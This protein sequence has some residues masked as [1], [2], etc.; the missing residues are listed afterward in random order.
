MIS[1]MTKSM[2]STRPSRLILPLILLAS[3]S[4]IHPKV[5]FQK[6]MLLDPLLDPAKDQALLDSV[7]AEPTRRLER[8]SAAGGSVGGATCPTCGG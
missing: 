7:G 4:C 1:F 8:G 5:K 3:V 6:S 2:S